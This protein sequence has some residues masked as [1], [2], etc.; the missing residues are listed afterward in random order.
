MKKLR[1]ILIAC[2]A[3][4]M[5]GT[6]AADAAPL[7]VAASIE[8]LQ[9]MPGGAG[10]VMLLS[11][12]AGLNKGGGL[13]VF[14]P[15]SASPSDGCTLFLAGG[16]KGRWVRQVNGTPL[17]VTMC[18]AWWDNNHD[19]AAIL[20]RAFQVASGLHMTLSLPGGTGKVCSNVT[21]ARGVIIRGQGMGTAGDTTGSPTVVNASCMKS[22][23]VF[24]FPTPKGTTNIEAP[25]YYDME[26]LTMGAAVPGGCIRW[27]TVEGGFTDN[28]SSQYYMMHPHAE[29]IY[30]N[31]QNRTQ[32]GL[33]CSKCFDGDFSQNVV[34]NGKHGIALEG[35]DV[36]CIG[37]AGPNRISYTGDSLIRLAGHGTFGNMDRVV[38]NELLYPGDNH[39]PFDSFIYDSS[40]SSTIEAN[41]IEGIVSGVKSAIHVVGGFS[42]AIL[43]N[44]IDVLAN[45]ASAAPH[46]LVAEGPFVNFRA[47]NNGCG[48]CVLGPA[49]FT[50]R[51]ST[52]NGIVPQVIT[53]GGNAANGD[54]GFPGG[55]Q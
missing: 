20:T 17:D 14:Q 30:C 32:I 38:G 4:A 21:A 19:D 2:F 5:A 37:C 47:T 49:L 28:A 31:L 50:N 3:V 52:Y 48:G 54:S 53:H 22:G 29:R 27:N 40:R 41:H 13:F 25:K 23:W 16:G 9:A 1:R 36:M 6:L 11:Y 35:S 33:Q 12:H 51:A 8:E 34:T 55:G 26:I 39:Q 45:S 46:W 18:G 7:S 15:G 42:H 43:N 44:D 24:D 10:A